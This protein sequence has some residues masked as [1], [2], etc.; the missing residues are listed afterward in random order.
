MHKN[1]N[2]VI[3]FIFE[4]TDHYID[5]DQNPYHFETGLEVNHAIVVK[6]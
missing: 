3:L 6:T 2:Y 4:S 5:V 1:Q